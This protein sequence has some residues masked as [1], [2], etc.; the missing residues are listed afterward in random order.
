VV[1]DELALVCH[2]DLIH[3]R[4]VVKGILNR[5]ATVEIVITGR[6]APPELWEIADYIT[7]MKCHRHPFDA[8][9]GAREGV[10]F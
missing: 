9:L 3:T 7:E 4:V 10:E 8:G 6:D 5:P 1:L 2:L